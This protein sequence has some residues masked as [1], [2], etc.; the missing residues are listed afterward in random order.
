MRAIGAEQA[1]HAAG[2]QS[3]L[4]IAVLGTNIWE[5]A[6]ATRIADLTFMLTGREP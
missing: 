4:L 2:L 6:D 3:R 1:R 5:H